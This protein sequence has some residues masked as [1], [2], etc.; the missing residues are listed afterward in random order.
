MTMTWGAAKHLVERA[1][2]GRAVDLE[3]FHTACSIYYRHHNKHRNVPRP[4]MPPLLA[5]YR[6]KVN[7]A[8]LYNLGNARIALMMEKM[9]AGKKESGADAAQPADSIA[10]GAV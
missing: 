3:Q 4:L 5:A 9:N 6:M 10:V 8:L 2:A 1:R 7:A